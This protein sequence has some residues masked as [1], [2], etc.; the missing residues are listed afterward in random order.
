[1]VQFL[2]KA[3]MKNLIGTKNISANFIIVMVLFIGCGSMPDSDRLKL[4]INFQNVEAWINLMPGVSNEHQIHITGKSSIKNLSADKV[5][6]LMLR[7]IK[8][9]Q[10][11]SSV[12]LKNINFTRTDSAGI[13]P[14]QEKIF[15]LNASGKISGGKFNFD[16]AATFIF[17]F[18]SDGK[19]IV[20]S[21]NNVA[22][23]KV[24]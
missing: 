9:I 13:I 15:S 18:S 14:G 20:D 8:L 2:V 12:D 4:N 5:D 1:M 23:K 16:S 3:Q 17:L 10:G 6:N 7:E 19:S 11:G 22:I 24:Y 21:L